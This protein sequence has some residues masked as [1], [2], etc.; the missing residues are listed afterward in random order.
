M[1]INKAFPVE[2]PGSQRIESLQDELANLKNKDDAALMKACKEFEAIFVQMMFKEMYKTIPEDGIIEK[3]SGS[4]IF[5]EMYIEEISK[6][7]VEGDQ[8]F[9]LADMMY[10]QFKKGYVAW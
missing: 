4:K 7:I 9:G 8:G 2:N 5:E 3:D 10:E 1:N 6:E